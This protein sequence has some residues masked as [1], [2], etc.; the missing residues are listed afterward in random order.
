MRA[1]GSFY[2]ECPNA[3]VIMTAD[4]VATFRATGCGN[5]TSDGGFVFKGVVY[6]WVVSPDG[7]ATWEL[8]EWIQAPNP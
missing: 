6:D 2:G 4:G 7:N 1:D 8:R 3:G 5:P